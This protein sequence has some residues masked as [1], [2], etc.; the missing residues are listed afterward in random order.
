MFVRDFGRKALLTLAAA[1]AGIGTSVIFSA[2]AECV[3]CLLDFIALGRFWLWFAGR[4]SS[5]SGPLARNTA[6][7]DMGPVSRKLDL[8]VN[9]A[10]NRQEEI[11]F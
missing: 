7:G 11:I 5:S 8:G 9:L 2:C 3:A 1:V 6:R 4:S 10:V